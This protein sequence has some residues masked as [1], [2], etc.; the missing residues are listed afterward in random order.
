MR[1]DLSKGDKIRPSSVSIEEFDSNHERIFGKRPRKQILIDSVTPL[2]EIDESIV[3][4]VL[5]VLSD[6]PD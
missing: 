6:T 3:Q 4:S 2:D 1:K 5:E